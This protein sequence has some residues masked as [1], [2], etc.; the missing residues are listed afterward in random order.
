M[1]PELSEGASKFK[2]FANFGSKGCAEFR[3]G[4]KKLVILFAMIGFLAVPSSLKAQSSG[5]GST[6]SEVASASS[7]SRAQRKAAR[8]QW[9]ADRKKK[10]DSDKALKNYQ[11]HIQTK[12]TRKRMKETRRKAEM[13]NGHKREF[14]LKRWFKGRLKTT[15]KEER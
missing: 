9:K 3:I 11:K 15:K 6:E 1:P 4:M 5:A 12:E 10:H 14:F 8:K 7:G 2:Q 13:V